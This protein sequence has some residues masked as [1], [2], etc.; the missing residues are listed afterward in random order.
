MSAVEDLSKS[1]QTT[2]TYAALD[3]ITISGVSIPIDLTSGRA[4]AAVARPSMVGLRTIGRLF[5][6]QNVGAVSVVGRCIGLG[7]SGWAA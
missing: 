6:N 5:D 3:L 2:L 4:F 7:A 1:T